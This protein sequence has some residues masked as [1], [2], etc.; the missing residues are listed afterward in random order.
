MWSDLL[1]QARDL[2]VQGGY[3]MP[4]LVLISLL[5]WFLIL[6]KTLY[7]FQARR[8]EK[9]LQQCWGELEQQRYSGADWQQSILQRFAWLQQSGELTRESLLQLQRVEEVQ[10]E[11]F[12]LTIQVLA[13]AAPLLGLLG[14]VGGMITTF[15][16]IS[17]F[18]TG[19]ARAMAAGISEALITTQTGLVVAV[20][21]LVI[22]ALLHRRSERLKERMQGFSLALLQKASN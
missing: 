10:I 21:G 16:V 7:F 2:M 9:S 3:V 20:P 15:D 4:P 12:V 13:G 6:L 11:R 1:T 19:N 5:M 8:Q 18:G 22:G 17:V 14:T